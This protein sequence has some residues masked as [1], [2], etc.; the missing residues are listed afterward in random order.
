[1]PF[2]TMPVRASLA[3]HRRASPRG[4]DVEAWKDALRKS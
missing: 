1:M 3:E 2:D 4:A